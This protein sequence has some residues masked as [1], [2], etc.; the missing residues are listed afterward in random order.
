MEAFASSDL[1][2]AVVGNPNLANI[3]S[4]DFSILEGPGVVTQ[5]RIPTA[6]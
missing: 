2:A 3:T 4:H 5:L 1:F 6:A